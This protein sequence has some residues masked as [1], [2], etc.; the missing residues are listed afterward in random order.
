MEHALDGARDE[1]KDLFHSRV[2]PILG[3]IVRVVNG[4]DSVTDNTLKLSRPKWQY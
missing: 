3:C 2:L 1:H 4:S